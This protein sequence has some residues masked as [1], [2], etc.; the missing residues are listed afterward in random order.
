MNFTNVELELCAHI[1]SIGEIDFGKL[2]IPS[3][4]RPYR[5]TTENVCQL[6]SDI[7]TNRHKCEYRIGSLILHDDKKEG[8]INLVDGQQ[9]ITTLVLILRALG[10]NIPFNATYSSKQS[11]A[12]IRENAAYVNNWLRDNLADED[13]S[14]FLEFIKDKC[15]FT[16][17]QTNKLQEAFQM[18]DSQNGHGK[19]LLPYNL[20]K[21]FHIRAIDQTDTSVEVTNEK[22]EYDRKWEENAKLLTDKGTLDLLQVITQCLYHVRLWSRRQP[23]K[24]FDKSRIGEFKGIQIGNSTDGLSLSQ[25]NLAVLIYNALYTQDGKKKG[26]SPADFFTADM[27]IINGSPFFDYVFTYVDY[28][29]SLFLDKDIDGLEEFYAEFEKYC[30]SYSTSGRSGDGYVRRLYQALVLSVYDKFGKQGLLAY[31]RK[32]YSLAYRLRLEYKQIREVTVYQYPTEIFAIISGAYHL[33]DLQMLDHHVMKQIGCRMMSED[34]IRKIAQYIKDSTAVP[35]VPVELS[36]D[37]NILF[38]RIK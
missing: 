15:K 9:R 1:I 18:F 26:T 17:I 35:I 33:D 13:R 29:K 23:A 20:L 5:W 32:L 36:P 6:L 14:P 10:E 38:S 3:Y 37:E 2:T 11:E 12:H 22:M 16:W 7:K 28:Y 4:Q 8:T 34:N 25:Y 30:R 24:V 31:F 19:E 27:P 21:A